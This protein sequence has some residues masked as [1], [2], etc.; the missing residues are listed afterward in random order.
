M[1]ADEYLVV[2]G[3]EGPRCQPLGDSWLFST[4]RNKWFTAAC[5]VHAQSTPRV[6]EYPSGTVHAQ[7]NPRVPEYPSSTVHAQSNPRVLC[8]PRVEA[9]YDIAQ[10]PEPRYDHCAVAS[11]ANMLVFGGV[12]AVDLPLS[13]VRHRL[14]AAA[15]GVAD[16]GGNGGTA[17]AFACACGGSIRG[18]R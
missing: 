16:D 8:T 14:R 10:R 9:G 5:G 18:M 4:R 1:D 13:D 17:H 12:G 2:F 7:S 6:P 15:G 11:G 3:G